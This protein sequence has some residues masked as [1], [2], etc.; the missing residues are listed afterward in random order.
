MLRIKPRLVIT[1]SHCSKFNKILKSFQIN[2]K[3]SLFP[4]LSCPLDPVHSL[5]ASAVFSQT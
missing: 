1:L 2:K 5:G 3:F 4:N